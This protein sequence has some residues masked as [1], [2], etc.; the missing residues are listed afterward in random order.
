MTKGRGLVSPRTYLWLPR[1]VTFRGRV[2][3]LSP[4][5]RSGVDS[6]QPMMIDVLSVGFGAEFSADGL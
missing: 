3:L 1:F 2:F 6:Q 5:P 4:D